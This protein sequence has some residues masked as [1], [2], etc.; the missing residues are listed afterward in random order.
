MF[1]GQ[2]FETTERN[3]LAQL[4]VYLA[5]RCLFVAIREFITIG[6]RNFV[7]KHLFPLS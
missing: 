1:I 7:N 2:N 6:I 3:K 5:A 4:R